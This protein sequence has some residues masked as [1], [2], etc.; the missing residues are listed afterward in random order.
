MRSPVVVFTLGVC[1]CV[2]ASPARADDLT[3]IAAAYVRAHTLASDHARVPE[4]VP[5][6]SR[7]TGLACSACHYQFL[8]LKPFGREFKANGYTLT[9]LQVIKEKEKGNGN[10]LGLSPIPM[11]GFMAQA[12]YTVLNTT[13]PGTQNGNASLPQQLSLFLAGGITPKIGIFSQLTYSGAD[14]ALGIDNVDV[15]FASRVE[16]K[17]D[18][19]Y[20]FT[21]NNNPTVTDLWNTLPAWGWPFV[22]SDAAPTPAAT[23]LIDGGLAQQVLGVTTYAFV[24]KTV[25]GEFGVYRSALQGL[26]LPDASASGVIKGVAPYWRVAVQKEWK[27]GNIELG[28]FGLYASQYP[29]GV[30]GSTDSR[31]DV[32]IDAQWEQRLGPG[33]LVTRGTWIDESA[34]LEASFEAGGVSAPKSSLKTF[35]LN[36]SFYPKQWISVSLGY[37][38]SSGTTDTLQYAPDPVAG[39]MTGSPNSNGLVGEVNYNPWQ[40]TRLGLQYVLYTKFNGSSTD[41][42]GAGRNASANNTLYVFVWLVF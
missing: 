36:T 15:R 19:T 39:S 31:T 40:N 8:S 35:K 7:Q 42:D 26:A 14:N 2:L 9:T 3:T 18:M 13:I 11:I 4:R 23:T 30:T 21:L 33:F 6:Y 37:F 27:A 25:Y 41:Y 5:P 16:G 22:S 20:G 12:S 32:G 38:Q 24:R 17:V 34:N 10:T 29:E 28:T 1:I